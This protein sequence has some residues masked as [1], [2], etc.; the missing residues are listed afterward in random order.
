MDCR[1]PPDPVD[2]PVLRATTDATEFPDFPV[3]P[4]PREIAVARAQPVHPVRR[5]RR[6]SPDTRAKLDHKESVD[7]PE[8]MDHLEIKETTDYREPLDVLEAPD[9][10]EWMDYPGYR[11]P[12]E[13]RP[14]C[15]FAPA[16]LDT[17]ERRVKPDSPGSLGQ[18]E[19]RAHKDLPATQDT[20]EHRELKENLASADALD[21]PEKMDFPAYLVRR[22]K[23]D[24]D[25]LG[26]L[27]FP[28]RKETV[29]FPDLMDSQ[30]CL[31][32]P[33]DQHRNNY[34]K[35][36][37][38]ACQAIPASQDLRVKPARPE[39]LASPDYP[40]FLAHLVTK[41]ILATPDPPVCLEAPECP[42]TKDLPECPAYPVFPAR[43]VTADNPVSPDAKD[44]RGSPAR[45]ASDSPDH[46]ASQD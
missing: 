22:V 17:P 45:R 26:F 46:L 8:P 20:Q 30:D 5:E 24:M 10:P 35:R 33:D 32:N 9:H 36:A 4:E 18:M 34:R 42:A 28:A 15:R 38:L 13:S 14:R 40:A 37:L 23:L 19:P 43:R 25:S 3:Y 29:V 31:E 21:C 44:P 6:D 1:V 16:H 41:E 12:K 11:D 2:R 39:S 27:D 7:T